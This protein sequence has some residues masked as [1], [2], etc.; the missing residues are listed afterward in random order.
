MMG[1]AKPTPKWYPAGAGLISLQGFTTGLGGL[2]IGSSHLCL[3]VRGGDL[4]KAE[5]VM[6][7]TP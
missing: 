3:R 7:E 2:P 5:A 6:R 1:G 4:K